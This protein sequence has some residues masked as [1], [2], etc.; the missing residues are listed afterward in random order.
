MAID[1]RRVLIEG[2]SPYNPVSVVSRQVTVAVYERR[3]RDQGFKI[4]SWADGD[5]YETPEQV[6]KRK[7]AEKA[8]REK[9]A[10]DKKADA[11]KPAD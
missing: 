6:E 9:A 4:V 8:A 5:E 11:D 3:Y 10:A 1:T 7:A 2:K